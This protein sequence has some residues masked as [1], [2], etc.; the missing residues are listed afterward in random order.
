MNKIANKLS[1]Y[2]VTITASCLAGVALDDL[3]RGTG[4]GEVQ[5]NIWG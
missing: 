4:L 5:G 2:P 1:R 3:A